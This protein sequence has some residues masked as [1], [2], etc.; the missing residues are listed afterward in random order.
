[1]T[2]DEV[3]YFTA[4]VTKQIME[5]YLLTSLAAETISPMVIADMTEAEIAFVAAEPEETARERNFLET[6]KA[7]LEKGQEVFKSTLGGMFR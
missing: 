5:R 3:K 1:M 2:Q 7:T 6:R 4:V